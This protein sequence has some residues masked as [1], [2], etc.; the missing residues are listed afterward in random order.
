MK[1]VVDRMLAVSARPATMT[2]T[3]RSVR[4]P[5]FTG[6]R[7]D[8]GSSHRLQLRAWQ[9]RRPSRA[10]ALTRKLSRDGGDAEELM[11]DDL[12]TARESR[13]ILRGAA[14]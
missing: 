5:G 10:A 13:R 9:H 11:R 8:P 7:A 6:A 1:L 4:W 2:T 3:S 14:E 12:A